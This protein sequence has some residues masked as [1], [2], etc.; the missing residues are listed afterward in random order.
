MRLL[1]AHIYTVFEKLEEFKLMYSTDSEVTPEGWK[2]FQICYAIES[3]DPQIGTYRTQIQNLEEL[4]FE[5]PQINM[6]FQ[7][8]FKLI[9]LRY[10]CSCLYINFRLLWEPVT[11]IIASYAY[12]VEIN[13][14]WNI[15]GQEL[16]NVCHNIES[17]EEFDINIA[18]TGC[19]FIGDLFQDSQRLSSKPDFVNYRILLWQCMSMF[20]NIAMVK[21]KDVVELLLNFIK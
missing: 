14:F 7:T 17:S 1:T 9:P 12:G 18:A 3:I 21:T 8:V 10:L 2:V 19:S 20:T 11:K 13:T 5:K 4:N 16:K 6:C 15:F